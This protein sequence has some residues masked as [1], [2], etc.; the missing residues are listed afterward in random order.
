MSNMPSLK[1]TCPEFQ[2]EKTTPLYISIKNLTQAISAEILL[3]NDELTMI[4]HDQVELPNQIELFIGNCSIGAEKMSTDEFNSTINYEDFKNCEFVNSTDLN[5]LSFSNNVQFGVELKSDQI[6]TPNQVFTFSKDY[7]FY[8]NA[9]I[10]CLYDVEQTV[11]TSFVTNITRI[12]YNNDI[13]EESQF[14]VEM[15]IFTDANYTTLVNNCTHESVEP[16][17]AP[18]YT[19]GQEIF[20]SSVLQYTLNPYLEKSFRSES[21]KNEVGDMNLHLNGFHCWVN[22][23]TDM[24]SLPH[25]SIIEEG[26][27]VDLMVNRDPGMKFYTEN[28]ASG[29]FLNFSVPVF[30]LS[31]ESNHAYLTCDFEVCSGPCE[32]QCPWEEEEEEETN[33]REIFKSVFKKFGI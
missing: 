8:F 10:E 15:D 4:S 12:F 20:I 14:D 27:G 13:E 26:C 18:C 17:H 11:D 19:V 21:K 30:T 2:P 3:L 29:S 1:L 25:Y 24:C 6:F 9:S 5:Q 31:G 23:N 32:A 22:D 7:S 16:N 33:Y 28:G